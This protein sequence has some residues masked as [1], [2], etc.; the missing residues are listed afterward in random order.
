MNLIWMNFIK[1]RKGL[2]N[3]KRSLFQKLS[4]QI[5]NLN[6]ICN[7]YY[8]IISLY[9]HNNSLNFQLHCKIKLKKL[10]PKAKY[11]ILS[12]IPSSSLMNFIN[13][14]SNSYQGKYH[15]P[16]QV[17]KIT[18]TMPIVSKPSNQCEFELL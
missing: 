2:K 8:Q 7:K 4:F 17:Q 10:S 16:N 3:V 12:S 5:I 6:I 9:L 15:H 11:L 1:S 18:I 14:N 13:T